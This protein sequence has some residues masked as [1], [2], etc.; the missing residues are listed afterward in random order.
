MDGKAQITPAAA[1]PRL[2]LCPSQ[3]G[4]CPG[5]DADVCDVHAHVVRLAHGRTMGLRG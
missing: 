1:L 3:Q 2:Q 5:T 4:E